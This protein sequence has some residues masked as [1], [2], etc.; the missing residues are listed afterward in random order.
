[1]LFVFSWKAEFNKWLK[2][3]LQGSIT[4]IELDTAK[5]NYARL[6]QLRLWYETKK[7]AV[8]IIGYY[9]LRKMTADYSKPNKKG[10]VLANTTK[11]KLVPLQKEFREV[12]LCGKSF[13]GF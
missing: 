1:M 3:E 4:V 12:R 5:D 2:N 7:P 11:K 8:C 10:K 6:R 9:M 13:N